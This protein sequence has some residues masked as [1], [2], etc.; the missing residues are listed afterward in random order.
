MWGID[1]KELTADWAPK[2]LELRDKE[3][4]LFEGQWQGLPVDGYSKLIENMLEGIAVK[5]KTAYFDHKNFD[6]VAYSGPI[7]SILDYKFCKLKYRSLKFDYACDETWEK[8]EYG[9]INLP[10]HQY[11]I[12][13]CNFKILHKQDSK[14]NFIQYQEPIEADKTY[15][16]MYPINT[17]DNDK[18]FNLYL[19]KICSDGNICPIGRLGLFKYLDMDKAVEVAFD[20]VEI[21]EGYP[22]LENSD[23]IKRI[24]MIRA[25]Y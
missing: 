10:Q 4:D 24:S 9:T 12:R 14:H 18:V 21:I 2:R 5:L 6:V 8:D 15:I 19:K 3:G 20:M 11:F 16:P 22:Y 7:D 23:K 13:K 1:P 17:D 25:A